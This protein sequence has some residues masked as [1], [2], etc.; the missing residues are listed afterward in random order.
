MGP[1]QRILPLETTRCGWPVGACGRDEDSSM[2]WDMRVGVLLKTGN[3]I[4]AGLGV[5]DSVVSPWKEVAAL[6]Y[7]VLGLG[8]VAL[9]PA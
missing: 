1:C 7:Q 4:P 3:L 6:S 2:V 5:G 8:L 9:S